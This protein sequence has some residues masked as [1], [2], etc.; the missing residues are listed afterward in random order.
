M[1][2]ILVKLFVWSMVLLIGIMC[3]ITGSCIW[4]MDESYLPIRNKVMVGGVCLFGVLF[5]IWLWHYSKGINRGNNDGYFMII[6]SWAWSIILI[7]F[8]VGLAGWI[9]YNYLIEMQPDVKGRN[10]F[11]PIILSVSSLVVGIYR[12]PKRKSAQQVDAPPEQ[13]SADR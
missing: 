9:A 5:I 13:S 3:V 6:S 2:N 4:F 12:M 10:P 11:S 8:G 7:L 1:I